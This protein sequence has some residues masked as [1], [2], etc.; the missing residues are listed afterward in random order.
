MVPD[1]AGTRH[2][3]IRSPG[4]RVGVRNVVS[5]F[6]PARFAVEIVES[7]RRL[8]SRHS[9]VSF[10]AARVREANA[11]DRDVRDNVACDL[12]VSQR[13]ERIDATRARRWWIGRQHRHHERHRGDGKEC[14]RIQWRQFEEHALQIAC[15]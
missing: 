10:E 8:E 7:V 3:A 5:V 9:A 6:T 13:G 1:A 14:P 4:Q 15:R 11:E 2:S 12:V